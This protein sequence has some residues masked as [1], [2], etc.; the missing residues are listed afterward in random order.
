MLLW[1][2]IEGEFSGVNHWISIE[3]LTGERLIEV[4]GLGVDK[5]QGIE[6]MFRDWEFQA[7]VRRGSSIEYWTSS[8]RVPYKE[9]AAELH[10]LKFQQFTFLIFCWWKKLFMLIELRSKHGVRG[11][12][13]QSTYCEKVQLTLAM[14]W[15][16][17]WCSSVNL[18][19][20]LYM[21]TSIDQKKVRVEKYLFSCSL[22]WKS[23]RKGVRNITDC[24]SNQWTA[25]CFDTRGENYSKIFDSLVLQIFIFLIITNLFLAPYLS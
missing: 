4:S 8:G 15:K 9:F 5:S 20:D 1:Q 23:R 13:N 14:F 10:S 7:R 2:V 11:S 24:I 12:I 25:G 21:T 19:T 3:G 16:Y 18:Y 22:R 17:I 6:S